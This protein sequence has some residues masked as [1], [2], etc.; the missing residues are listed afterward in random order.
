MGGNNR[1]VS[2]LNVF[3]NIT[4]NQVK[5]M[6]SP[7]LHRALAPN[8]NKRDNIKSDKNKN[9]NKKQDTL[10]FDDK[11]EKIKKNKTETPLKHKFKG[12][13]LQK[14][15]E[16]ESKPKKTEKT[17]KKEKKGI[18]ACF[19]KASNSKKSENE[20]VAKKKISG[21]ITNFFDHEIET[22]EKNEIKEK[23]KS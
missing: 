3:S 12:L 14:K 13:N 7:H 17:E 10:S 22:N 15:E 4:N 5:T 9:K 11:I 23:K 20:K 2:D 8:S 6:S 1:S 21:D 16:P 19:A 18:A